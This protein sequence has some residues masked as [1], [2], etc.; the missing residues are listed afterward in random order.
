MQR[1]SPYY[2]QGLGIIQSFTGQ[3]PRRADQMNNFP[4]LDWQINDNN[5]LTVEYSRFRGSGFSNYQTASSVNY[6]NHSFGDSYV[7]TDFGIAR[8]STVVSQSM[9]NELRFQYG[10]DFEYQ[11]SS[12][13]GPN[14][15]SLASTAPGNPSDPA[16]LPLT[17][18]GY[19]YDSSNY[20]RIGKYSTFDSNANP[21]ERRSRARISSPGRMGTRYEVR[22][23]H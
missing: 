2:S 7:K 13:P 11:L 10:R 20:F 21:N 16:R 5:R 15:A 19:Y 22:Y 4:R 18:I 8:L 12:P 14:E 17:R 1:V 23:R 3:V 9:V 6:G